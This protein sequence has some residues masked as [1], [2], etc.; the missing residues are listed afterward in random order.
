MGRRDD[1]AN[2]NSIA[3]ADVAAAAGV[4][5]STVSRALSGA[6]GVSAVRRAQIRQIA[7]NLGYIHPADVDLEGESLK[8]IRITLVTPEADRWIFGSI[9]AGLNDVLSA[10]NVSLRVLQGLSASDR[11]RLLEDSRHEPGVLV[12]VPAPHDLSVAQL[13]AAPHRCLVIAGSLVPGIS[14]VGV[15]DV[16]IG[17][18]AT[19]H[20]LNL[21]ARTVAFLY[22]G[23][24]DDTL[25]VATRNR[26]VGYRNAMERAGID[27]YEIEVSFGEGVGRQAA[28]TL[29]AAD[30]LPDGIF[31]A[32]D[33]MAAGVLSVFR[34]AGVLVPEDVSIIGVDDHPIAGLVGLTTIAQPARKQGR[35]AARLALRL[36]RGEK[37]PI[38]EVLPTHLI[39]RETTRKVAARE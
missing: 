5:V 29:L 18:K 23:D 14:S 28:E 4:A 27:P 17:E 11:V 34:Q 16:E 2:D 9:L 7:L 24:H 36:A 3:M 1:G 26:R 20:L 21:G 32:A 25:G 15:D 39:I 30:G 33:E 37:G 12:L 19:N 38:T 10:E 35:Y 31:C 22:H 13:Q 8:Q 6:G